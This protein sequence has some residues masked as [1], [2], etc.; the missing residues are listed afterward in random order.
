MDNQVTY[1]RALNWLRQFDGQ[2]IATSAGEGVDSALHRIEQT[3]GN[4]PKAP[5]NVHCLPSEAR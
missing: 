1:T 2:L 3:I 4:N 5:A